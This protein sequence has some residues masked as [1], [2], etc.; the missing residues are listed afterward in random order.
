[1]RVQHTYAYPDNITVLNSTYIKLSSTLLK[2]QHL[3]CESTDWKDILK[4]CRNKMKWN[5][6]V[7]DKANR[8]DIYK[9]IV[10]L[11]IF[12]FPYQSSVRI[13]TSDMLGRR[14]QYGGDT[15]RAKIGGFD[16]F[17]MAVQLE[18]HLDGNY[19]GSFILPV[20]SSGL[21]FL[22]CTLEHSLCDGI[23]DPPPDWFRKGSYQG[24]FQKEGS[25]GPLDDFLNK[26]LRTVPFNVENYDGT[27]NN[28]THEVSNHTIKFKRPSLAVNTSQERC[29]SINDACGYW[30]KFQ[31]VT[32]AKQT[33]LPER[34]SSN[35]RKTQRKLGTLLTFGDSLQLRLHYSMLQACRK[36]FKSC[37]NVYTWTYMHANNN[38]ERKS[39]ELDG[40]DFNETLFLSE[41]RQEATRPSM[42]DGKSVLFINF[43]LHI[44]MTL[45]LEQAMHL[46]QEFLRMLTDLRKVHGESRFPN[47]IWKNTTPPRIEASKQLNLTYTRFLTKERVRVWNAYT[48]SELCKV[49]IP[50][51]DV[52]GLAA[53][54]NP[55]AILDHVHYRNEVFK[56]AEERLLDYIV[57]LY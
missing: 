8:T 51:L 46:F 55:S 45:P 35:K 48:R 29:S 56:S 38:P 50:V 25:L 24:K 32:S 33:T 18:D 54:P 9:S 3:Q 10:V 7:V 16:S 23:R 17:S 31:F 4:A 19:E 53:A 21:Y 42:L 40:K 43:G 52:H 22:H 11:S 20:N 49:G 47:V 39:W 15:W 36:Q 26:K 57:N 34:R 44:T 28:V 6:R 1:M 12:P 30:K 13:I 2:R 5:D 41:I 14:K 27:T 37:V